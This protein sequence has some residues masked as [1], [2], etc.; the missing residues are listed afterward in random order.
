MQ[1]TT[2]QIVTPLFSN[3]NSNHNGE[4]T[5]PPKPLKFR[6]HKNGAISVRVNGRWFRD[7]QLS[8]AIYLSAPAAIRRRII[9]NEFETGRS[10]VSG[11]AV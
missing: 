11:S 2:H 5:R 10:L 3:G 8:P 4:K 1:K 6:F 9:K 7:Q